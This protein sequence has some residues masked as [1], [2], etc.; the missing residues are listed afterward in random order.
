M[1]IIPL[2]DRIKVESRALEICS[3][4]YLGTLQLTRA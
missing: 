1:E 2:S 3:Y 4:N